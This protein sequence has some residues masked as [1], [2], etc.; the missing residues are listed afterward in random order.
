MK[1]FLD[2]DGPILDTA[3]RNHQVYRALVEKLGGMTALSQDEFWSLKREGLSSA[4]LLRREPGT[5]GV[6]LAHFQ[7]GWLTEIESPQS[8]THDRIHAGAAERIRE[9]RARFP[10]VLVTLRQ[11]RGLLEE[12]LKRLRLMDHFEAVLSDN[13][14]R[15]KGWELKRELIAESG[16]S[17]G[18]II[19][20]DT[21]VDIRAGKLL[22]IATVGVSSGVRSHAFLQ[23]ESPDV[24]VKSLAELDDSLLQTLTRTTRG[25]LGAG[26]GASPVNST[27]EYR[28]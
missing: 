8:L 22:N 7:H 17:P 27:R 12:Q 18:D 19:V 26:A 14:N 2:L 23:S 4:D 11:N 20:G 3:G 1:L 24:L 16:C 15:G 21:E 28:Q 13:P 25:A 6:N 5:T 10:L 9:W